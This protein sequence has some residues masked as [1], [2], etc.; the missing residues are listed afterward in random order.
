MPNRSWD[1][2]GAMLRRGWGVETSTAQMEII[3]WCH[4]GANRRRLAVGR[5][6]IHARAAV[7]TLALGAA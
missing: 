1:F 4:Y 2:A 3:K 7:D 6:A 5:G